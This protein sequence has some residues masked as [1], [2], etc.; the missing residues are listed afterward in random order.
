MSVFSSLV[1]II[2]S[3]VAILGGPA[4]IGAAA[5]I[6]SEKY[7]P[8]SARR[9][10]GESYDDYIKRRQEHKKDLYKKSSGEGFDPSMIHPASYR[11]SVD[12]L[13]DQINKFGGKVE[14][15]SFM[16]NGITDFSSR[17]RA[18]GFVG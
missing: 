10:K 14:R 18:G 4:A 17:G 8:D 7:T 2:G 9:R 15:A 13:A 12:G 3:I 1:T 16:G 6:L 5:A 11:S